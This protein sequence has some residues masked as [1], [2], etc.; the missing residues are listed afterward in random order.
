MIGYVNMTRNR[1][2]RGKVHVPM[3]CLL[4]LEFFFCG[5]AGRERDSLGSY[6]PWGDCTSPL[7]GLPIT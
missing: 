2:R 7:G 3:K 6:F 5:W 1:Y 4:D